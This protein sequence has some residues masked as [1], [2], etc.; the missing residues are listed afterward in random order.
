[1]NYPPTILVL[2]GP[3]ASGKS[4]VAMSLA[5]DLEGE[6]VSADS[7]QVYKLLDIGTAK[8]SAGDRRRIRH[9]FVDEL[10]PDQGFN[11]GEFGL[12]GRERIDQILRRHRLPIVV[13]G[14]GLYVQ[15]LI[16]GFFEGPGADQEYRAFLERRLGTEGVAALIGTL[17]EIDPEAASRIDPTKPR[18]IIRALEVFHLTGKRLSELHREKRVAIH[19]QTAM[20]GLDWPRPLLYQRIN[21]RCD[22]MLQKGLLKEVEDL[23]QKGYT[24]DLNALNTVGYAEAFAYRRGE[25]SYDE[26]VR[27]FKQNTRRYAKR[28]LTWFRRDRRI[29][30]IGVKGPSG[31][32]DAAKEIR[33]RFRVTSACKGSCFLVV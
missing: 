19:F 30:W 6:I 27:L 15:S 14:S 20:Y 22:A 26:L 17:K 16:D 9:H 21:A 32:K 18:R 1:V 7:R 33:E 8:P 11:A 4:E 2:V 25:I 24:D 31:L 29:S 10:L 28:Q 3:T 5:A 23:E 13:G 12:R